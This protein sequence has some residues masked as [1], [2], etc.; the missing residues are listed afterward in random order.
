MRLWLSRQHDGTY[1][2]SFLKPEQ[3]MVLGTGHA[4]LYFAAGEPVG[5]RH[6]CAEG[7]RSFFGRSLE[8]MES[9]K[10]EISGKVIE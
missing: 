1:M 10:V 7:V 4:D 5:M 3:S 2:L 6:L 9:V 8:A